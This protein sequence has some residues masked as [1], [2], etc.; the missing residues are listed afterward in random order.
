M[1][2]KMSLSPEDLKQ[3]I[4]GD[5]VPAKPKVA[6]I[7]C[8]KG[9]QTRKQVYSMEFAVHFLDILLHF[10]VSVGSGHSRLN[11]FALEIV[12]IVCIILHLLWMVAVFNALRYTWRLRRFA[13]HKI[14]L[15]KV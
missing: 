11:D 8:W 4:I 10:F 5:K 3:I 1:R 14:D 7:I 12:T 9:G 15:S 13:S 2:D 6:R